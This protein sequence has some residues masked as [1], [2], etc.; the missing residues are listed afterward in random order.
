MKAQKLFIPLLA[1]A[2]L[3][4]TGVL[5]MQKAEAKTKADK[6][7]ID[8]TLTDTAGNLVNLSDYRGKVVVVDVWAT[9]CGYCTKEIPTLIAL[10]KQF[11]A[12]K[13]PA[14]VLGIA[15][16]QDKGSV[17]NFVKTN[18][19]SYPVL[20]ADD[21]QM[22]ALGSIDGVP[23]KFIIDS[24][25]IVQQRLVGGRSKNELLKAVQPYLPKSTTEQDTAPKQ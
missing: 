8:F 21:K 4:V 17:L 13:T 12:D 11:D 24:N 23:T 9:W 20:Y 6:K 16:D 25:G 1:M 5:V 14:Q 10:Q 19:F 18:T 7:P 15:I 22:K 2:L 3:A